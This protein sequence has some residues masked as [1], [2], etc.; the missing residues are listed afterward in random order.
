[1]T[2]MAFSG[3]LTYLGF[4]ER[5]ANCLFV[6]RGGLREVPSSL[7]HQSSLLEGLLLGFVLRVFMWDF[8]LLGSERLS[9]MSSWDASQQSG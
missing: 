6:W 4:C 3:P 1:M 7:S 8:G 2:P 9:V 5:G